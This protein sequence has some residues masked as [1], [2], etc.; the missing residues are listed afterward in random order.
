MGRIF[1]TGSSEGLGL[2]AGRLL[3]E[4]GHTVVLHARNAARARDARAALPTVEAVVTGDVATIAGVT[5]VAEEANNLGRFDT[6]I[7]N[8][9]VG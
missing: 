9:A 3:V 2:M 7:H 1:I 8:V 5:H 6:V 4:Q